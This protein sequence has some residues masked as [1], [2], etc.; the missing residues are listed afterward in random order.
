[1]KAAEEQ[2]AEGR[3]SASSSAAFPWNLVLHQLLAR[4]GWSPEILWR[5]TPREVAWVLGLR[6]GVGKAPF[7]RRDF[8]DLMHDF[9]DT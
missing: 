3:K 1:M 9:P 2:K 6:S 8:L 4:R 7:S 5:T